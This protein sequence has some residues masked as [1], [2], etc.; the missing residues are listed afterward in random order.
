MTIGVLSNY[1]LRMKGNEGLNCTLH[2]LNPDKY[3]GFRGIDEG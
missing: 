2:P 3:R 1:S